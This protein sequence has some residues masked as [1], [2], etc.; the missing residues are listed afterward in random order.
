[1]VVYLENGK[2]VN[3]EYYCSLLNKL[4]GKLKEKRSGKLS[5]GVMFHQDNAPCH[6]SQL[7]TN[8]LENL[9]FQIID[10]PPYSTDLAP[11]DFFL[12]P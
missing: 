9:G 5:R 11:S 7:T 10:H 8:K 3:S 1:M 4:T 6:K 2:I 12:L